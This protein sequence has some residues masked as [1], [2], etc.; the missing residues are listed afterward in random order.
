MNGEVC[1]DDAV[2][3][4]HCITCGDIAIPMIV[5]ELR[6]DGTAACLDDSET[7]HVVETD[8]LCSVSKG[9]HLLVHAGVAITNLGA[10]A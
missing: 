8:L 10:A 3:A 2:V 6:D 7:E 5:A 4:E 9:D 1:G